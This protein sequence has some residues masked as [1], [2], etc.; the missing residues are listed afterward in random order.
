MFVKIG[1]VKDWTDCLLD[2]IP[3]GLV[4]SPGVELFVDVGIVDWRSMLSLI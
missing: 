4:H 1:V 2:H 3:G